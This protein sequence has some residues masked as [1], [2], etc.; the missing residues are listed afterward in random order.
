MEDSA[1]RNNQS[2]SSYRSDDANE[3]EDQKGIAVAS[4]FAESQYD[5]DEASASGWTNVLDTQNDPPED[6]DTQDD[7]LK[8]QGTQDD[9]PEDTDTQDDLPEDRIP[10]EDTP[11]DAPVDAPE[12]A[13]ES[14]PEDTDTQE[15]AHVDAPE[16][17]DTQEDQPEDPPEDTYK[18]DS[19]SEEAHAQDYVDKAGYPLSDIF[20]AVQN[21]IDNKFLWQPQLNVLRWTCLHDTINVVNTLIDTYKEICKGNGI[22]PKVKLFVSSSTKY[23]VYNKRQVDATIE[24]VWYTEPIGMNPTPK[25]LVILDDV[26]AMNIQK[27]TA[28]N[29]VLVAIT[30]QSHIEIP[31][32]IGGGDDE[33]TYRV[34]SY[35]WAHIQNGVF[36]PKPFHHMPVSSHLGSHVHPHAAQCSPVRIRETLQASY[37]DKMHVHMILNA[38]RLPQSERMAVIVQYP[39]HDMKCSDK[40][41]WLDWIRSHCCVDV[42]LYGFPPQKAVDE[43]IEDINVTCCMRMPHSK[44]HSRGKNDHMSSIGYNMALFYSMIPPGQHIRLVDIYPTGS[45]GPLII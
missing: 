11:V 39:D 18:Q 35:D 32:D 22:S 29:V 25:Q 2:D 19:A 42:R 6:T 17:T 31:I 30:S 3:P 41:Q 5:L 14:A 40:V 27:W 4:E 21:C 16:D 20:N 12:S 33:C 26:S 38:M 37:S 44:I 1:D 24:H 36:A 7:P 23:N 15:D 9:A 10:Q 8:D 28:K 43:P 45:M 13:T 34:Y